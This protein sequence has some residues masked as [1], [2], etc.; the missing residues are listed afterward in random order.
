MLKAFL[1]PA[2]IIAG[3]TGI[4]WKLTAEKTATLGE[5]IFWVFLAV[6][7]VGM[8]LALH[9]LAMEGSRSARLNITFLLLFS[10][11][12]F[13]LS[14]THNEII[15]SDKVLEAR[16][17]G[18]MNSISLVLREDGTFEMQRFTTFHNEKYQGNYL[19]KGDTLQFHASDKA[20]NHLPLYALVDLPAKIL[21]VPDNQPYA[22]TLDY[23]ILYSELF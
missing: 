6:F 5:F 10:V 21:R 23:H 7:A 18:E 13:S 12:I 9:Q 16:Q 22:D 4:I 14:F 17:M 3:G 1:V 8:I 19:L 11:G 15:R 20:H 2:C